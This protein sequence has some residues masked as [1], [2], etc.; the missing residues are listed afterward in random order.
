[1]ARKAGKSAAEEPPLKLFYI[2]YNEERWNNWLRTL[3]EADFEGDG[4]DD[5]PEGIAMLYAFSEDITLSVLKIVRLWQNE[6]F[7]ADEA[8]QKIDD[9]EAIVLSELPDGP[10]VELVGPVQ[11]SVLV[12]FAACRRFIAGDYDKDVKALIKRGRTLAAQGADET[13]EVA[14]EIGA[15]V[16]GGAAC[17]ARYVKDDIEDPTL[18]D[19]WLVEIETMGEAMKSLKNFDEEPGESS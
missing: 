17:C 18:F 3:S 16:I 10:L 15:A 14:A 19:D 11:E 5:V 7:K 4:G 2:F 8:L 1:M 12:L 13:L 6:R 9:I